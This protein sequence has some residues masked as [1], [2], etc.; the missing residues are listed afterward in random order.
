MHRLSTVH[1]CFS[2]ADACANID[3]LAGAGAL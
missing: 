3:T 2:D 1:F